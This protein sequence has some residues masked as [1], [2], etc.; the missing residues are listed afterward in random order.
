MTRIVLLILQLIIYF[1]GAVVCG[2]YLSSMKPPVVE[3]QATVVIEPT[4][5]AD[6]EENTITP[7]PTYTTKYTTTGLNIR[8][9][10]IQTVI[11]IKP[12]LLTQP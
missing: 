9:N 1:A 3:T 10:R 6:V 7:T 2:N 11:Y 8:T 4:E 12:Y 5:S